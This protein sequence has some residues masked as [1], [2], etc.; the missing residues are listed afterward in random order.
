MNN[1][2]LQKEQVKQKAS[3]LIDAMFK[4]ISKVGVNDEE[5]IKQLASMLDVLLLQREYPVN[6]KSKSLLEYVLGDVKVPAVLSVKEVIE[7]AYKERKQP[8]EGRP[9]LFLSASKSE[10]IRETMYTAHSFTVYSGLPK[11]TV[12]DGE[13]ITLAD[14][15]ATKIMAIRNDKT[16][17]LC[18][19]SIFDVIRL[20]RNKESSHFDIR[21]PLKPSDRFYAL[22]SLNDRHL[23][24]LGIAEYLISTYELLMGKCQHWRVLYNGHDNFCFH[25]ICVLDPV[26]FCR[27]LI[28]E[29]KN[30]EWYFFP[31]LFGLYRKLRQGETFKICEVSPEIH[32]VVNDKHQLVLRH[33]N[34]DDVVF[35]KEV[36]HP[37]SDEERV[38]VEFNF[39]N[40]TALLLVDWGIWEHAI[41]MVNLAEKELT[42]ISA[43]LHVSLLWH[44]AKSLMILKR[45]DE[46]ISCF[47]KLIKIADSIDP[48]Q[49]DLSLKS[50]RDI[51]QSMINVAGIYFL[52]GK[53]DESINFYKSAVRKMAKS[54]ETDKIVHSDLCAIATSGLSQVVNAYKK[55]GDNANAQ[56]AREDLLK[57]P[58][59]TTNI[60]KWQKIAR[61]NSENSK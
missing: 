5:V 4:I 44:K 26:G 6:G 19:Y 41:E 38:E 18:M 13:R 29:R 54:Y 30:L 46:S 43:P 23:V 51:G 49:L 53:L 40:H 27:P 3:S 36:R 8:I 28:V 50:H 31:N 24:V 10:A 1:D 59:V 47:E 15:L 16:R 52:Q 55:K 48:E 60:S 7:N 56:K 35:V 61:E 22:Y 12:K 21:A 57:L 45:Y 11:I 32:I 17:E 42:S 34:G 14:F 39:Y 20:I 9:N 25:V 2:L 33:K 58:R 37:L